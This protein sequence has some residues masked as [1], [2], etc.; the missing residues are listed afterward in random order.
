MPRPGTLSA[1]STSTDLKQ[2]ADFSNESEEEA[3]AS[4]N[5]AITG[6]WVFLFFG[7]PGNLAY[8]TN[9]TLGNA[10]KGADLNKVNKAAK[11]KSQAPSSAAATRVE[12]DIRIFQQAMVD[13]KYLDRLLQAGEIACKS[14]PNKY[15]LAFMASA[16]EQQ[17][18]REL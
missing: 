9:P 3:A 16:D 15:E 7:T 17:R 5:V 8:D 11:R 4:A 14:N 2:E 13:E 12:T 10:F 1:S 6:W 18:L